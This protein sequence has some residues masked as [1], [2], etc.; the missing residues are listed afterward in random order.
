MLNQ[1]KTAIRDY[2]RSLA[3]ETISEQ[4]KALREIK[5][6]SNQ[7]SEDRIAEGYFNP[8]M[9]KKLYQD[10]ETVL[11]DR[12]KELSEIL[13]KQGRIAYKLMPS[14][15]KEKVNEISAYILDMPQFREEMLKFNR[16]IEQMTMQ[17]T[18]S[19]Q[20]IDEAKE[21]GYKDIQKRINQVILRG[22]KE[23]N[24]EFRE[25]NKSHT[26]YTNAFSNKYEAPSLVRSIWKEICRNFE[27]EIRRKEIESG[28]TTSKRT[29]AKSKAQEKK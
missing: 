23:A 4:V 15:V 28:K 6:I 12:L 20:E 26:Q 7:L 22:A 21:N 1:E 17:Y 29:Q 5:E 24:Q 13:P 25:W 11:I 14:H 27:G 19:K 2:I 9:P 10:D 8:T 16:T 3:K 18:T